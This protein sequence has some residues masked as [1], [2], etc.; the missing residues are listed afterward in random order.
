[1]TKTWRV[2]FHRSWLG[3]AEEGACLEALR[4]GSLVGNGPRS[5]AF[6]KALAEALG[7]PQVFFTPSCTMALQMALMVLEIGPGDEVLCPSFTFVS[8]P[9]VVLATG[10]RPV[11]VDI[12]KGCW[13]MDPEDAERKCT[14]RT[15]ALVPVHYAG[16]P[17]R[18]EELFAMAQRRGLALI[19]DAAQAWGSRHQGRP[20]GAWGTFGCF[21]F[22][23]TKN[24]TTGEG[25]ALVTSREDL[26][27][28]AETVHEKG[29]NRAAYVRGE[30]DRY[31]WVSMGS[32]FVQSD[33]LAALGMTQLARGEEVVRK[34]REHAAYFREALAGLEGR[35]GLPPLPPEGA[36]PNGHIFAITVHPKKRPEFL[37]AVRADG[38]EAATHYV[39]LHA[40]PF[41]QRMFGT[42]RGDLPVTEE[43]ADSLVRLPCYPQLTRSELDDVVRAVRKAAEL[44]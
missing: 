30:V 15:R 21:S 24:L 42:R 34:R 8:M 44:L 19:E 11:F 4:A 7:V 2:P 12:E 6:E 3:S 29:T 5:K 28:R 18:I 32:S 39:P 27:K 37:D 26:I 9:N 35:I 14:P 36:E 33:L 38:I 41:A 20:L 1:M 31:T 25:G 23:Q 40:S 17:C 22:H 10:A 43:I 16:M 13:G